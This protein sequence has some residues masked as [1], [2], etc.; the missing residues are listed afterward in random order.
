[1]SRSDVDY[2]SERS[3]RERLAAAAASDPRAA[4]MHIELARR[5]EAVAEAFAAVERARMEQP[6][7]PR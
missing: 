6:F 5:Y 2:F 1:M 4:A 7:P 3:R